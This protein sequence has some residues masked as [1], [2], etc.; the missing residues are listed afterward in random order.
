MRDIAAAAGTSLGSAYY[1]YASKEAMLLAYYEHRNR[2][3]AE[4]VRPLLEQS[5]DLR[6][7]IE[8]VLRA[9]F[10]LHRNDRK[11][12][13]ALAGS[14]GDPTHPLSVFGSRTG[15]IR[16]QSIHLFESALAGTGLPD[17]IRP[18]L[19]RALWLAYLG[20]ILYYVRDDSPGQ[21]RT[22]ALLSGGLDLL[23]PLVQLAAT[24]AFGPMRA[25]LESVLSAAGLLDPL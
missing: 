8:A 23:V 2:V 24:D 4:R 6:A 20:L 5:T 10:D 1:Y 25:H 9:G 15:S 3:H 13:A 17:E 16:Q 14:L 19:A 12:L 22:M 7:R 11:L 18:M 21:E